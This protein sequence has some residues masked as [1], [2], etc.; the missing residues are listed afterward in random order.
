M[1]SPE[2][3]LKR[4]RKK[5]KEINK[6]LYKCHIFIRNGTMLSHIPFPPPT[7]SFQ[8]LRQSWVKKQNIYF[9]YTRVARVA[10]FSLGKT[11]RF[12]GR[13]MKRTGFGNGSC[14]MPQGP[15]SKGAIFFR[16]HDLCYLEI[17]CGTERSPETNYL[18][19]GNP[20]CRLGN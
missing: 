12:S 3:N 8:C 16:S 14:T 10:S 7:Y 1:C 11:W 5:P 4:M 20:T 18:D 17:S 9:I 19:V 15:H 13:S 2:P 6:I